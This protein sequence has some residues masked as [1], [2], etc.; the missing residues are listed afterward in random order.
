MIR[1]LLL[2]LLW[3]SPSFAEPVCPEISIPDPLANLAGEKV[4]YRISFLFFDEIA[5]GEISL[6]E[7]GCPGSYNAAMVARST[8]VA[9]FVTA[10]RRNHYT[11]SV[12]YDPQQGF[13][14][15]EYHKSTVGNA[16]GVKNREYWFDYDKELVRRRYDKYG[17]VREKEIPLKDRL[18]VFDFLTVFFNLRAG[19]ME[20]FRNGDRYTVPALTDSGFSEI[21]VDVITDRKKTPDYFPKGGTLWKITLDRKILDMEDGNVYTWFDQS[22]K[23]ARGIVENVIGLGDVKGKLR[24]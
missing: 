23:M 15:S 6:T 3:A 11:S 19:F 18:P 12:H 22:G 10:E 20:G 16:R 17:W 2:L 9:A 14:V 24:K 5:E 4:R 8:G 7:R 1:I 13:L 21:I